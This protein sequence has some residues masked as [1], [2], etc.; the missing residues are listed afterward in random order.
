MKKSLSI[1]FIFLFTVISLYA[2]NL[3][4]GIYRAESIEVSHGWI[5][6]VELTI[7]NG[8][9]VKV[10]K[11]SYNVSN[12]QLKSKD[13]GYSDR[14]GMDISKV[15]EK[16]A[17]D[18]EE[19][20]NI[21]NIDTITGATSSVNNFKSLV[22]AILDRGFPNR[23]I[24][25]N[26]SKYNLRDGIYR[27]EAS[28][29]AH[30]WTDFL[31]ITV[32]N[33]LIIKAKADAFNANGDLKTK[34]QGYADRMGMKPSEFYSELTDRLL[35][36]QKPSEIDTVTGATSTSNYIRYLFLAI[37]HKGQPDTTVKVDLAK[38]SASSLKDGVY[39]AEYSQ[40][41]H[42]WTDFLEITVK[43]G[44]IVK[45]YADAYNSSGILK[46]NDEAYSQRMGMDPKRFYG[47]LAYRV[48]AD[49]IPSLIDIV[50]GATS[51]SNS[52][53]E[54]LNKIIQDGEPGKLLKVN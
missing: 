34:D 20:Q 27:A 41:T 54:L 49:Q 39:R 22:K 21:H 47:I 1:L 4:D 26:T 11:D 12:G 16:L 43:N 10:L 52:V 24:I 50:T 45:A 48:I 36:N 51:T 19:K 40:P 31:E 9:I 13:Q 38:F 8:N 15:F 29:P 3:K 42:G 37:I 53:R 18:L 33:G 14:M 35:N 28:Q 23:T 5:D 46:T 32:E 25:V 6:F 2:V 17:K 44:I 7:E 30:G